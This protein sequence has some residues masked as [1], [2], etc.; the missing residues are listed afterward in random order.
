LPTAPTGGIQEIRE[1]PTAGDQPGL[2]GPH[3]RHPCDSS[4]R[5][6]S[7]RIVWLSHPGA[8]GAGLLSN[9][10]WQT[11]KGTV[12]PT[13]SAGPLPSRSIAMEGL[14]PCGACRPVSAPW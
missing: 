6:L 2:A 9:N 8:P 4:A 1:E 13:G 7:K 12:Y 3:S 10:P 14:L 5:G 11:T